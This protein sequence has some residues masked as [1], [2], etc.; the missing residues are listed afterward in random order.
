MKVCGVNVER[1]L[2][3]IETKHFLRISL[4][5]YLGWFSNVIIDDKLPK[6]MFSNFLILS[7]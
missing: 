6:N 2:I 4:K 1:Q 5:S 3:V 7:R